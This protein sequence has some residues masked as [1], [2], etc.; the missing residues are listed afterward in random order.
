MK[1]AVRRDCGG[2]ATENGGTLTATPISQE[3]CEASLC[4]AVVQKIAKDGVLQ[5]GRHLPC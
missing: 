1:C 5:V 3:Q 2:E 4:T